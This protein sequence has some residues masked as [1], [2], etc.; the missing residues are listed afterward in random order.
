MHS[1]HKYSKYIKLVHYICPP[2]LEKLV[3]NEIY[4]TLVIGSVAVVCHHQQGLVEQ[5]NGLA[6]GRMSEEFHCCG[7]ID[8][9]RSRC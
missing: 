9:N 3:R 1:I 4:L 2:F 8:T 6:T 7:Y 5:N